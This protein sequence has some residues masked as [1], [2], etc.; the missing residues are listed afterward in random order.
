MVEAAKLLI[1]EGVQTSLMSFYVAGV[2]RR[3]TLA[4]LQ[5]SFVWQAQYFCKVFTRWLSFFVACAALWVCPCSL[6][7]ASAALLTCRVACFLRIAMSE[8]RQV[9][10]TCQSRGRRGTSWNVV[11]TPHS[12][13]YTWYFALY[14]LHCT[15]YTTLYTLYFSLHVPQ[16]TLYTPHSTLYTLHVTLHTPHCTLRA[17][18]F[19]L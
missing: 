14:T 12:T 9:V 4:C 16:F 2:A 17:P 18:H 11:Y 3:D 1:F 13:L 7:V 5:M 10:T 15:L 6:C 8:R 19:T